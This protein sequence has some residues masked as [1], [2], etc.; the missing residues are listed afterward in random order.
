MQPEKIAIGASV[1]AHFLFTGD[2]T[3]LPKPM[4]Y[5]CRDAAG[6][7]RLLCLICRLLAVLVAYVRHKYRL[8]CGLWMH[9]ARMEWKISLSLQALSK[10]LS[11][12]PGNWGKYQNQGRPVNPLH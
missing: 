8:Y 3:H 2:E 9:L 5:N 12:S 4:R 6:M 7:R 1:Q 10:N 11:H